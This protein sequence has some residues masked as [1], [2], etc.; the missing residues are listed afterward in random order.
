MRVLAGK[1]KWL[2]L[3]AVVA[4]V[5][6][7]VLAALASPDVRRYVRYTLGDGLANESLYEP[8]AVL[9]GGAAPPPPELSPED[10]G[11]D[12][13]ALELAVVYASERNTTALLVGR[14]GHI[15][16]E[17]YFDGAQPHTL[18]NSG[19][20]NQLLVALAAGAAIGERRIALL[21]EPVANYLREW[22]GGAKAN[23]TIR[24][25]LEQTSGL[26][27]ASG[28]LPWS[29]RV[30]ERLG[31]D[32][33]AE[34]LAR[35]LAAV[36]GRTYS[37]QPPDLTLAALVIER[38]T[39]TPYLDYLSRSIWEPLGAADAEVWL[40]RA[41]GFAHVDCC[42]LAQPRDWLRVGELLVQDGVYQGTQIVPPG[43]VRQMTTPSPADKSVGFVVK[44]GGDYAARDVYRVE[45]AG[46]QRIWFIPSLQLVIVRTGNEPDSAK[47]WDDATIPDSIARGTS[48]FVPRQAPRGSGVDPA[49][50]AP[51]H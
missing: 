17:R 30:R 50:Y 8:R 48:G 2:V 11:I 37:A 4:L 46:Q 25:L 32:R 16:F 7:L 44:M 39:K 12:P 9:R 6:L 43:W 18:A 22:A 42:L 28:S 35:P 51:G 31:A 38:A 33:I 26:E 21:D 24:H 10:A 36:P 13:K 19:E 5:L 34:F 47:G 49:Q 1:S 41:G 20:W 40:E 3:S 23:V 14:R 29:S 15:V 45:A 27:A